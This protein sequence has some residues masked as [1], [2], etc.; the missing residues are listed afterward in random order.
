MKRILLFLT[1]SL[2]ASLNVHAK[3]CAS[4][5]IFD[6]DLKTKRMVTKLCVGESYK[7]TETGVY[8]VSNGK[9]KPATLDTTS[10]VIVK[11]VSVNPIKIEIE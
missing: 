5:K 2:F 8:T 7:L 9:N 11:L 1:L 4:L 6:K 10:K 3:D